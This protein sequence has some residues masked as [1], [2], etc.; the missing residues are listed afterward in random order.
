[1]KK[2]K[3]FRAIISISSTKKVLCSLHKATNLENILAPTNLRVYQELKENK[4][5]FICE[6]KNSGC[7]IRIETIRR[8]IDDYILAADIAI[9]SIMTVKQYEGGFLSHDRDRSRENHIEG[10]EGTF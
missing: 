9:R 8:T 5:I 3:K 6:T 7:N 1:M 10:L 4:L 2:V